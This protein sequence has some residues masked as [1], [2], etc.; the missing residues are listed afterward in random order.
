MLPIPQPSL[1]QAL[2]ALTPLQDRDTDVRLRVALFDGSVLDGFLLT[3]T[4]GHISLRLPDAQ[5]R[6]IAA[7]DIR[8]LS[9]ARPRRGREWAL[10]AV[11]AAGAIAAL[12]G[13]TSLPGVGTYLGTH[14]QTAFGLVFYGGV[15][16]VILLLVR[17]RLREWLTRWETVVDAPP[18]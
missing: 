3:A 13:L 10:A 7:Q 18:E 16:L 4:G 11:G 5:A 12:V 6:R 9:V 1:S 14:A 17:T 8:R 15:G 2:A